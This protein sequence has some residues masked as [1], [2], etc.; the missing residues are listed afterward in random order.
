[1]GT[2]GWWLRIMLRVGRAFNRIFR[3]DP[4]KV[5]ENPIKRSAGLMK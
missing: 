1:M 5:Q 2:L 3:D 4:K